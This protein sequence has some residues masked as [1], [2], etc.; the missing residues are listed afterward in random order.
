MSGPMEIAV[1]ADIHG[2]YPA[3]E[4][5]LDFARRRGIGRYLFLGDYI[6]DFPYPRQVLDRLYEMDRS[7]DCRFIRGNRE[8]YMIDYRANGEKQSDGTAWTNCSA[9]GAL[10]YCYENL[11]DRDIDW[12]ESLPIFGRWQLEGAPPFDY[13]HGSPVTTRS[14]YA[15]D[16]A[17]L[18]QMASV[19]EKFLVTGH[20]HRFR[21]IWFR[22]GRILSAGSVGVPT[23]ERVRLGKPG[24]CDCARVA[25]LVLLHLENGGWKPELVQVPYD[26]QG[27]V[28][29][30]ES[31]GLPRR[32]PVWAALLRHTVCTG[33]DPCGAVP[34][35]AQELYR[36]ETGEKA[37]WAH[38]PEEYWRR[39]AKDF[40][41]ELWD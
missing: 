19:P 33:E 14:S 21:D 41:V 40:G 12:F 2:N 30:L 31:A 23:G 32:A 28:K 1:L 27:A 17:V 38:V 24:K 22:G 11:T 20:V 18:E 7:Y 29:T 8:E 26:W 4:A 25:Q 13:C 39:A 16:P 6:T 34:T 5:C 15:R 35:R 10:L 3:L 36:E 37:D 9:Q